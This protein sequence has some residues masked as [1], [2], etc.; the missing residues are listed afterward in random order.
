M[1]VKFPKRDFRVHPKVFN[2]SPVKTTGTPD[3]TVNLISFFQEEFS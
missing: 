3:Q 2:T 1:Q